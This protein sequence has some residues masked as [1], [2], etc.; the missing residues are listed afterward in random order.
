MRLLENGGRGE[1][2]TQIRPTAYCTGNG[3]NIVASRR[4]ETFPCVCKPDPQCNLLWCAALLRSK[5]W[6]RKMTNWPSDGGGG[7]TRYCEYGRRRQCEKGEVI[8]QLFCLYSRTLWPDGLPYWYTINHWETFLSW[9]S[10]VLM[11][12]FWAWQ[13]TV[14]DLTLRW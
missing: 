14:D 1:I 10:G 6:L 8:T 9:D 12:E 2:L 5:W 7:E 3:M 4:Q 11:P 13:N